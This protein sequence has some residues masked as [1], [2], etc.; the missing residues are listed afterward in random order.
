MVN[1]FFDVK[2]NILDCK[3]A[4]EE[5]DNELLQFHWDIFDRIQEQFKDLDSEIFNLEGF[6]MIL[7]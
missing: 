6:L 3:K 2:G 7:K 1:A 5:F 4:I